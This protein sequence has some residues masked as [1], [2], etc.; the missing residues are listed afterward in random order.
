MVQSSNNVLIEI[1]IICIVLFVFVF[2]IIQASY[3]PQNVFRN[4]NY[5]R[6]NTLDDEDNMFS[7]KTDHMKL[8]TKTEAKNETKNEIQIV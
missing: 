2:I 3:W 5:K 6:L 4:Y 7:V 8:E 1:L